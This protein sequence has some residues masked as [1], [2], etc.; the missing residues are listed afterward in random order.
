MASRT[1][2]ETLA[3][4]PHGLE[5]VTEAVHGG[6][7]GVLDDG[8]TQRVSRRGPRAAWGMCGEGD[9]G[10]AS[11][12]TCTVTVRARNGLEAIRSGDRLGIDA[13]NRV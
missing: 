6:H 2:V 12:G 1:R 8:G 10:Y 11:P 4:I 7:V 3:S 13:R 9:S 5:A